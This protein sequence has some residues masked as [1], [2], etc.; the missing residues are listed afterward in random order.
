M[1]DDS[2]IK[3]HIDRLHAALFDT[4]DLQDVVRYIEEKTFLKGDRFSF[5]DHEFQKD[6][7][8]DT[9]RDINVMKCAQVGMTEAMARYGL[10]VCRI[11]PYFSVIMTMP[12]SGDATKFSKARMDPIINESPDLR[13]AMGA[14]L[15]NSEIKAIASSLLYLRGT[16]GTTAALSVPAD[17]LIH[18]EIDRSD[19]DTL[20]QYQSRIKHSKWKLTRKFGT[21]TGDKVGIAL[22]MASSMRKRHM[23]KC[24][25]CAHSFVPSFHTDVK[26]PGFDREK[27]EITKYNIDGIRWQEA[28][29]LCPRCGKEPSLQ[30]DRREWV[31]ENPGDSFDAQGYFVTPFSVP[32]VVTIP[33]L[34][35]EIT[36]YTTW[37][38]FANQALGET[39]VENNAQMVEA[40]LSETKFTESL[41]SSEIHHL[42]IDVGQICH[43]VVG[44]F[45]H[46]NMLLAVH[47]E[48]CVL[49]ELE[50]RKRALCARF[51]VLITVIDAFPE[52]DK[53]AKM[54]QLDKRLYGGVY[55]DNRKLAAYEILMV[56]KDL[57]AG[58]L[59]INQ[60]AI[61][62]NITFDEIMALFK[63][64][65]VLWRAQGDETDALFSAHCLDMQRKQEFDRNK[66]LVF[67]W[68][69]SKEGQDHFHHAL[70]Y[71]YVA[72]RLAPAA[73]REIPLAGFPIALRIKVAT[74]Q[75]TKVYGALRR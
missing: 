64:R 53:V 63:A 22:A 24:H 17:M 51:K 54:Q 31:V 69:K 15:D 33:S 56:G 39:G 72:T 42:G 73:N 3:D 59:P 60:A 43:L 36:K 38:E 55:R 7:L 16:N 6:I 11:M 62:R 40:D 41:V 57:K 8:S 5:L 20:A 13:D 61:H 37:S 49:S 27:K 12:F 34:V 46:D 25:H 30:F 66:E 10:A 52:T 65:K 32:N 35:Q 50:A 68:Q 29:L 67:V 47:K 2:R 45:T 1:S 70:L 75:E 14:D 4:Y 28:V 26:I 44:R 71:M 9:S 21:P 19:P 23:C 18:D 74:R 58:K 48:R